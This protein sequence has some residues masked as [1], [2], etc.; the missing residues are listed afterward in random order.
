MSQQLTSPPTPIDAIESAKSINLN[1]FLRT[2]NR[3]FKRATHESDFVPGFTAARRATVNFNFHPTTTIRC[4]PHHD[5]LLSECE[6]T[7]GGM[8]A[9]EGIYRLAK[10]N[11]LLKPNQF[12]NIF[13]GLGRFHMEKIMLTCFCTYLV[14]SEI[15]V[16]LVETEYIGADVIKTVISGSH[17]FTLF[18]NPHC[19][20]N[21][22]HDF[23]ICDVGWILFQIPWVTVTLRTRGIAGQQSVQ[24][25]YVLRREHLKIVRW[26]PAE[27]F[28]V[29]RKERAPLSQSFDY[30]NT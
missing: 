3:F 29:N 20:F 5:D 15:F 30:R 16:V 19:P 22:T 18:Q 9:D 10:D 11:Q 8:W 27:A 1:Y 23:L 13:Q 6:E 14:T 4:N 28:W 26:H 7:K 21:D 12:N 24:R 2:V 17:W 25:A